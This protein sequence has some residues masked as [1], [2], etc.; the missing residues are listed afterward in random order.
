MSASCSSSDDV[1]FNPLE[2][3][4]NSKFLA[5]SQHSH[6]WILMHIIIRFTKPHQ[7][8]GLWCG[9]CSS[10]LSCNGAHFSSCATCLFIN[11]R[12]PC[13]QVDVA[14]VIPYL[15]IRLWMKATRSFDE[16]LPRVE[17]SLIVE[18]VPGSR[19]SS[20]KVLLWTGAL[21]F[22]MRSE[23]EEDNPQLGA[24]LYPAIHPSFISTKA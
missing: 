16:A 5:L 6:H 2:L 15:W 4:T 3:L 8:Q 13:H 19:I 20:E 18:S 24:A 7:S 17:M 14:F 12:H 23:A 10:P 21:K 11:Y 9:F 1:Q 22:G